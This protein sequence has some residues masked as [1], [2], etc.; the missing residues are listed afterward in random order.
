MEQ[1]N[2]GDGI[3]ELPEGGASKISGLHIQVQLQA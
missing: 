2:Y 1:F 3:S